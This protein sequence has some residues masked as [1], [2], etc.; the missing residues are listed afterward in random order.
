MPS[1]DTLLPAIIMLFPFILIFYIFLFLA[2]YFSPGIFLYFRPW[3]CEKEADEFDYPGMWRWYT[4]W[5]YRISA[6]KCNLPTKEFRKVWLSFSVIS[7]LFYLFFIFFFALSQGQII[8]C[9]IVVIVGIGVDIWLRGY[10]DDT[11]KS[12]YIASKENSE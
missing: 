11:L 3:I 8:C 4:N 7:S 1:L 2:V 5:I 12:I 10:V 6:Y 9:A